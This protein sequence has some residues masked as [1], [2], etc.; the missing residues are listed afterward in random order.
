VGQ[1]FDDFGD[2]VE[3][4]TVNVWQLRFQT[5][6]RRLVSVNG[7]TAQVTDDLGRYR[8]SGLP[9]GQYLVTASIGQVSTQP[10]GADVPGFA[11]TYFPG[12][13]N[14]AEARLVTV[15]RSQD[16][17]AVDVALVSLQT[18]SITGSRVG[19]DGL[20]MGGSI[21]L[22]P[23]QRSRAIMTPSTG[24][25]LSPDGRFEFP[26][27]P[28]GEYV[29]QA[30]TGR[31][32]SDREGDFVAQFVTVNGANVSDV[33]LRSTPG[34]TISGHVVFEGD[35][36]TD[37]RGFAV[38]PARADPDR[39]PLSNG[40]IARGDVRRDLTFAVEGIHGPRRIAVPRP[41]TGWMLKS[42][43]SGGVDITDVPMPFGLRDQSLSDVEVVLTNRLT[44]VTGTVVDAR[45]Q[46]ATAYALLVFSTDRD[47]WYV[48]SRFF[49]RV[50][51]ESAGNFTVRGLP[52][53]DYYLAPVVGSSV[54]SEGGDAWQDPE[55]LESVAIGATRVTLTEGQ[56]LSVSAR[57]IAK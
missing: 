35:P 38:E 17:S 5:G 36:P 32:K 43:T 27:V 42:V 31:P 34:S 12:T 20:P 2:P 33:L 28:P 1:V 29:I 44:E 11:P 24:A 41:P 49:R 13:T 25:R 7:A 39:T 47:R 22:T 30:D 56:K 53:G 57:V 15:P 9:P 16:V 51:P 54:L 45:G 46:A 26:N 8:V 52:P 23:S 48:G 55:F 37:L 40:S 19:S 10:G 21:V 14:P 6:R 50:G 3:G 18:A 4:A